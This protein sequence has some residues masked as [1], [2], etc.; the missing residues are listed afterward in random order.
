VLEID[1]LDGEFAALTLRGAQQVRESMNSRVWCRRVARGLGAP[2]C[3]RVLGGL[4]L[5]VLDVVLG[6]NELLAVVV[7]F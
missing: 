5:E 1:D 4:E 2:I 6:C 3:R 7:T